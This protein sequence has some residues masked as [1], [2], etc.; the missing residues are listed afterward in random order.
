LQTPRQR[1]KSHAGVNTITC[2]PFSL[3]HFAAIGVTKDLAL[4]DI[5]GSKASVYIPGEVVNSPSTADNMPEVQLFTLNCHSK[6]RTYV[7]G[8][9]YNVYRTA[10]KSVEAQLEPAPVIGPDGKAIHIYF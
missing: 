10:E 7:P 8:I 4:L 5:Y 6:K 3:V 1:A 2:D 9:P